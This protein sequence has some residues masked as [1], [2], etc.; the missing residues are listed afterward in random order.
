LTRQIELFEIDVDYLSRMTWIGLIH[1]DI[2]KSK[3]QSLYMGF[4]VNVLL[5]K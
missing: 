3:K 4:L 5:R 1:F 2:T